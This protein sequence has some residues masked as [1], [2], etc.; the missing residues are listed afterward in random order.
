[1]VTDMFHLHKR[2]MAGAIASRQIAD[3]IASLL[4]HETFGKVVEGGAAAIGDD[5]GGRDLDTPAVFPDTG[6][7][8][9]G[10]VGL[11]HGLV[12][13]AQAC[14]VLAP[15]WRGGQA[16]G[17]ADAAFLADSVLGDDMP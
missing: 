14:R 5:E 17:V 11:E 13:G 4:H 16:E 1:M 2:R 9:K 10:H 6:N 12:A 7:A 3:P 8:V 15:I